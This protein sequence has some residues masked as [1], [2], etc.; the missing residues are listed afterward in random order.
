MKKLKFAIVG[1]GNRGNVYASYALERPDK[2]EVV[3]VVDTDPIHLKETGDLHKL[4]ENR[5]FKTVEDFINAKLECD[6]VVNATMD[7]MHIEVGKKILNAGYNMLIEKPV[8]NS[9]KE[10]LALRDLAKKRGVSIVVCHVLRYTPFYK[11]IKQLVNDGRLGKILTIEMAE[12]VGVCHFVDSYIRG[13]WGDE[14]ECGS[15]LLLAKCCHDTDMMCWLNNRTT[16]KSVM[17]FGGRRL[18]TP[19]N[20]PE[21]A[22]EFCYQCPHQDTCMYSAKAVHIIHDEFPFQT[23]LSMGK[24]V[25]TIT[26]EEKIEY[27]KHHDYGKCVYTLKRNLVDRQGFILEFEDGSIGTFAVIGGCGIAGRSIKIS[28]TKGYITGEIEENKISLI[29]Y[30][31]GPNVD[32]DYEEIRTDYNLDD[33]IKILGVQTNAGGHAGGDFGLMTDYVNFLNG[34]N[35]SLSITKID[36]SINSHLVVYASDKSRKTKKVVKIK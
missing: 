18:F 31:K 35:S 9:R 36:D 8:S 26:K 29:E 28:G 13:H 25:D 24:P 4:P 15:S 6:S 33:Q 20:A 21:G 5:R 10:V 1:C 32:S 30:V 2:M 3:A 11:T 23:W 12:R 19:E 27:L 7:Q 22:T 16:P 17:S 14:D 34:D